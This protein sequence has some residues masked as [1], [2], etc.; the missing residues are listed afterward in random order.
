MTKLTWHELYEYFKRTHPRLSKMSLGF[1]PYAY[2]EILIYL[3][4]GSKMT[5]NYDTCRVNFKPTLRENGRP[6]CR[7]M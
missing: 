7:E 6:Y 3:D 4:D 1:S 2:A 5:Y